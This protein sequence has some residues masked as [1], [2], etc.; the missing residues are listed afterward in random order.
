MPGSIT[1]KTQPW[2]TVTEE[3]SGLVSADTDIN[4][5][6]ISAVMFTDAAGLAIDVNVKI[7]SLTTTIP[8]PAGT[9]LGI[10]DATSVIQSDVN[11]FMFAM[12][13]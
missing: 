6:H 7:G 13:R 5:K 4:V 9:P 12:G 8:I 10:D 2:F 1:G 11:A 3:K